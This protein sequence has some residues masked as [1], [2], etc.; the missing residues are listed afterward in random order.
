V[1]I[2]L[3]IPLIITILSVMLFSCVNDMEIVN[4]FI[5]TETEPDMISE[6]FETLFTDSARLQMKMITPLIKQFTSAQEQRDEYPEGLHVWL[7]ENTGELK[8]EIT[9]N[10]ARFDRI[11]DLWEARGNVIIIDADG[12]KLETEQFYWDRRAGVVYSNIMTTLTQP[13]GTVAVGSSFTAKQDFTDVVLHRGRATI[14]MVEIE[15]DEDEEDED[16]EDEDNGNGE[17]NE[18]EIVDIVHED[19]NSSDNEEDIE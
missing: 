18:P 12:G 13:N 14:I 16:E 3:H 5:D 11:D 15:E 2:T 9:A 6:N 1:K 7:Y 8:G 4:R 19:T 17:A 10:W